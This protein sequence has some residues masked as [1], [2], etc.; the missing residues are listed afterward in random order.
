MKP[1]GDAGDAN[2]GH[3]ALK[4]GD[5]PVAPAPVH[6][7]RAPDVPV[8]GARADELGERQLVDGAGV[9]VGDRL[10]G[11]DAVDQVRRYDEPAESDTRREGLARSSGVHD[12]LRSE[13]LE[14]AQRVA[15]VAELAVV[16][17]LDDQAPGRV[18]PLGDESPAPG[19]ERRADRELMSGCEQG[20]V[21]RAE[22][23]NRGALVVDVH[24]RELQAACDGCPR[25]GRLDV[26]LDCKCPG[27]LRA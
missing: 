9:P 14:R 2:R 4:C 10:G 17:V 7:T 16:V 6:Q 15:V 19:S 11:E 20:D 27:A 23:L 1:R 24:R 18:A 21:G 25:G 5:E 8:V 13:R 26:A 3:V 12:P 22:T